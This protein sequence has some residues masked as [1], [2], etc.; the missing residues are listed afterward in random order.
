MTVADV[1]IYLDDV[2]IVE[3]GVRA[4]D[5][6][7]SAGQAVMSGHDILLRVSL[8]RGEVS[9]SIWTCDLSHDYVTIN[10][11]YRT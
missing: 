10:A 7:E 5:Y 4:K 6:L 2:C 3:N 11:E 8:G 1:S 9:E